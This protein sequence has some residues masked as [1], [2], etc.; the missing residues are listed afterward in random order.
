MRAL[1]TGGSGYFGSLLMR[2]LIASG[3][4][5]AV[6]DIVDADDRPEKVEFFEADIRDYR[7]V[8]RAASGMDIIFHNVAQVPLA[9]DRRLFDSVNIKG[10]ENLVRAALDQSVR[11]VVYTSSSAVFGVPRSNPVTEETLPTPA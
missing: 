4:S 5:C 11:K 10:T 6:L 7:A 9:R 8:K 3:T 1:I 2:K